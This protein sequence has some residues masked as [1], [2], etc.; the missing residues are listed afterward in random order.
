MASNKT[1]S[2]WFDR[3]SSFLLSQSFLAS[4]IDSSLFVLTNGGDCVVLLFYVDDM[5]ITGNS[6][7][8][9]DNFQSTLKYEFSMKDLGYVHHIFGIQVQKTDSGLFLPQTRY[10]TKMLQKAGLSDCKPLFTPM[11]SKVQVPAHSPPYTDP[12]LYRALVGSLQYLKFT[13]T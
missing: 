12:M 2:A 9:L 1:L 6:S 13:G 4:T 5:L 3:F 11:A 8:L 7:S 10:A